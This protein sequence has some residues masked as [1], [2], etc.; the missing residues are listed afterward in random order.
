MRS[1]RVSE[2]PGHPSS[3]SALITYAPH[4]NGR[5]G[6]MGG[7]RVFQNGDRRR[8]A[9]DR[10]LQLCVNHGHCVTTNMSKPA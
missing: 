6:V 4:A 8:Q 3:L 5:H 9:T 10:K 2:A 7:P 1:C